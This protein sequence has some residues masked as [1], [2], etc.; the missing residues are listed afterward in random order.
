ME[1]IFTLT[2]VVLYAKGWYKKT[3][4]IWEDLKN[5][6]KLDDYSPFTKYDV[7]SIILNRFQ[8]SKIYR[9]TDLREVLNGI[10]PDNCWKFG[11]RYSEYKL[12]DATIYYILS[13]LRDL[14]NKNWTP[15]TPKYSKHPK[16]KHITVRNVYEHFVK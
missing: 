2:N 5:I 3:D 14:D 8:E 11:Y 4:D 9:I 16:S 1:N 12:E 6:L 7:Y 15:K 10:H 13:N